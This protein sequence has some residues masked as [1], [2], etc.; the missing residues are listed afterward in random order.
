MHKMC[1]LDAPKLETTHRSKQFVGDPVAHMYVLKVGDEP[2]KQ[3]AMV[4][5]IDCITNV[6]S[7]TPQNLPGYPSKLH[8]GSQGVPAHACAMYCMQLCLFST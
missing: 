2:E 8:K 7:G 5:L 4:L 3:D 1:V 6:P